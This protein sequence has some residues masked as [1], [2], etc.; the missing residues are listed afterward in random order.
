MLPI[1]PDD[2]FK[3]Y[4]AWSLDGTQLAYTSL[5]GE[6]YGVVVANADGSDPIAL[7]SDLASDPEAQ[8]LEDAMCLVFLET[9]ACDF[10]RKEPDKVD[11]ILVQ[12]LRKMSESGRRAA[13]ELDLSGEVTAR[14]ERALASLMHS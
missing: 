9:Q 11:R 13:S 14:V 7:A 12:T 4:P 8:T 10:A 6:T 5:Q 2:V 1:L 3:R